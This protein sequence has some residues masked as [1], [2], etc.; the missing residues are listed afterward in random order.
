MILEFVHDTQR[1]QVVLESTELAHALIERILSR[2]PEWYVPEIVR[3]ADG[4]GQ[5]LVQLQHAR[6]RAPDL[7]DLQRMGDARAV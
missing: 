2:V 1:L 6:N 3:Q 7:G 5:C 4:L